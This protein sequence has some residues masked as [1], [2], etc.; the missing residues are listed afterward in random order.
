[1]LLLINLHHLKSTKLLSFDLP[2]VCCSGRAPSFQNSWPRASLSHRLS[3]LWL[4]GS[5]ERS[6]LLG[7]PFL[8]SV[9]W[10]EG[11]VQ[12]RRSCETVKNPL[13]QRSMCPK[14]VLFGKC[15]ILW[16]DSSWPSD[17][18]SP[19]NW[20]QAPLSISEFPSQL[21]GLR[22][23]FCWLFCVRLAASQ[24]NYLI[25]HQWF[26]KDTRKRLLLP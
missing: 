21:I 1:M 6:L 4:G 3:I 26:S 5:T 22:P 12:R 24:Y 16:W 10:I 2:N 23:S 20:C 8:L 17:R 13:L 11:K 15:Q 14:V 7:S 9:C 25:C 19:W 18:R